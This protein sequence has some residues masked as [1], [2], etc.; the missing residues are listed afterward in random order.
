MAPRNHVCEAPKL[1]R[2]SCASDSCVSQN[3]FRTGTLQEESVERKLRYSFGNLSC[4][5]SSLLL[6]K[7]SKEKRKAIYRESGEEKWSQ[8]QKPATE[9][10]AALDSWLVL[11][12]EV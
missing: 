1:D 2:V 4:K 3:L 8:T 12:P 6:T 10:W 11:L 7:K 9:S 5:F